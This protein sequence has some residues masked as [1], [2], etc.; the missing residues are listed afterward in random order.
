M[1]KKPIFGKRSD[2]SSLRSTRLQLYKEPD[3][4]EFEIGREYAERFRADAG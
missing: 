2:S 4:G 1:A 3:I